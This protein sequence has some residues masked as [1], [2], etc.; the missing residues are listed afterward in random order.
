M[1]KLSLRGMAD[2]YD[3]GS[4]SNRMRERRFKL[5]EELGTALPR[6]LRI[7]D[8]GGT[9]AFWEQ[10]GWAGRDDVQITLVNLKTEPRKHANI[11][12]TVGDATNLAEHADGAFDIAFSNSVI[13][14]LFEL[15]A[16]AAMAR[17]VQRVA[18]AFWVQT[19]N[20]WFP[21]EPHFLVPGWHWMPER[22]RIALI[23]RRAC[24]WRGPCPDPDVAAR[25]VREIRLLTRRQLRRL[26]PGATVHSER[27]AG[28]PKSFVVYGG[29]PAE[30]HEPAPDAGRRLPRAA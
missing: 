30:R 25:T 15:E 12:P 10:R 9:N 20:F 16:Q 11:H 14:H 17:E 19:P 27:I 21:M 29:F 24:G 1:T 26:F 7:L 13:E 22:A 5:F 2:G 3:P 6:P 8:I 4:F 23:R 18:R 28:L